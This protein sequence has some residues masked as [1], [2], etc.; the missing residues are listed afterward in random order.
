MSRVLS[1]TLY[2]RQILNNSLLT[3]ILIIT[4]IVEVVKIVQIITVIIWQQKNTFDGLLLG[5]KPACRTV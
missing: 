3:H 2:W 4:L 1:L 5:G